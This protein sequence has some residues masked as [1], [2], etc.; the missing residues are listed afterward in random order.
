MRLI[1]TDTARD[2]VPTA[3]PAFAQGFYECSD[4]ASCTGKVPRTQHECL[5]GAN[6]CFHVLEKFN[7]ACYQKLG[8][9]TNKRK[10]WSREKPQ[11]ISTGEGGK[12]VKMGTLHWGGGGPAKPGSCIVYIL[13]MIC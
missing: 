7:R 11:S 12:A 13:Y 4:Q 5:S 8:K 6:V 10:T 3:R 9:T 2:D 1:A